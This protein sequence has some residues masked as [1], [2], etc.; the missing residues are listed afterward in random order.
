M[1]H[2]ADARGETVPMA[3]ELEFDG[4]RDTRR[5]GTLTVLVNLRELDRRPRFPSAGSEMARV[6]WA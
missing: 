2:H 5:D 4:R 6:S 3:T 1:F